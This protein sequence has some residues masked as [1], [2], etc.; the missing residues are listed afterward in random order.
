MVVKYI[1][2]ASACIVEAYLVVKECCNNIVTLVEVE[3][4]YGLVAVSRLGN[5]QPY[6]H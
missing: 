3:L 5:H 4:S 2:L 1:L 6:R